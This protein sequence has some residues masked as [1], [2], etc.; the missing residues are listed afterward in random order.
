MLK[1]PT[2]QTS[3]DVKEMLKNYYYY[4]IGL[5]IKY[6]FTNI[7]FIIANTVD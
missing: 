2:N 3:E 1:N 7:Y 6:I 4:N 5:C